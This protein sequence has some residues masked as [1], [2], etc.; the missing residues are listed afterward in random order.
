VSGYF[1]NQIKRGGIAKDDDEHLDAA[2]IR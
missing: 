1:E 2:K